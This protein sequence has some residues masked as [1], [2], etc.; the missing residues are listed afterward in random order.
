MRSRCTS[1][2]HG[3]LLLAIVGAACARPA[4]PTPAP[5]PPVTVATL[6]PPAS[7]TPTPSPPTETPPTVPAP[8]PTAGVEPGP[9]RIQFLPGGTTATVQ[10]VTATPGKDRFVLRALA[11]QTMTATVSSSEGE[12]ILIIYGVDGNVMISDHASATSWSGELPTTQDYLVDVRSVGA[13]VV[14]FTLQVVIPPLA[15]AAP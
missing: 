1:L 13:S 9:R 14:A 11:G 8:S 5:L 7:D 15:T 2:A 6:P 10:G 3:L 4:V 12:V